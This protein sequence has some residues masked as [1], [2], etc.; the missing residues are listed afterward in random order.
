MLVAPKDLSGVV[1]PWPPKEREGDEGADKRGMQH[2]IRGHV[3]K[4]KVFL[5]GAFVESAF[6]GKHL[7]GLMVW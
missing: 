7:G 2:A 6:S 3:T 5:G 1:R 4:E